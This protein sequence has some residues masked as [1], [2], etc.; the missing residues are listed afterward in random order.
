MRREGENLTTFDGDGEASTAA[1]ATMAWSRAQ[2]ES[3]RNK[4]K[5]NIAGAARDGLR[6]PRRC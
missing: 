1:G 6:G 2:V 5:G 4:A 3:M